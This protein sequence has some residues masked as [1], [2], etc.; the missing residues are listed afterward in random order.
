VDGTTVIAT[1]KIAR[2]AVHSA[3]AGGVTH[4]LKN[5]TAIGA[6]LTFMVL[7][8]QPA[9]GAGSGWLKVALPLRPNGSTGWISQADVTLTTTPYRL[10]VSESKHQLEVLYEGQ[11]KAK[12]PVGVGKS[13]TPT[14]PGTYYLTELIQ[15][16][17]PHGSYGPYAFGL[18]AYS[19]TLQTFAGG[20]G[21]LGLHGTDTPHGLGHD[22]SHGCIRVANSVISRLA[23]ELPLGTPIEIRG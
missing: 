3:P 5:P 11:S 22:V 14:P 9:A 1:A 16:P 4:R 2:L 20:P 12:Y 13:V 21:Q 8:S 19:N 10:V 18:S 23:K 7:D 17:D 15:P 6:P